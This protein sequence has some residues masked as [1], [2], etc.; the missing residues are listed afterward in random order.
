MKIFAISDLHMSAANP[1]PMTIFGSDWNDYLDKI[2]MD[3]NKKV[4]DEDIVL[5]AGDISWAMTLED[6]LKDFD[7]FK[8]LPG[9]KV[10]IKGNHDFWWKSISKIRS[11]VPENCYLIQND[12]IKLGKFVF[13]G[14]R[15]WITP[16]SPDYCEDDEK[17]Y[18]REAE[19]LKMAFSC[20][21]KLKQEGDKLISLLHYPPFN[22]KR[23]SSLF[24]EIFEKNSV[25]AVVYGHLHGKD[26]RADKK[27]VK[28][29]ITYYLTSC[30]IV[31]NSLV[32]IDI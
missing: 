19:R 15:G 22:V 12:A 25:D 26:V 27:L 10:L 6:G 23:E 31:K 11:E 5:I 7:Y 29:G 14:S 17:I 8:K 9:K 30:D 24:T 32:E 18:L 13:C 20:A 4:S 2:A 21:E 16:G 28:N 3:W 1:K